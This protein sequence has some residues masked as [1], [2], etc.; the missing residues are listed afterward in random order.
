MRIR[1]AQA[2]L[3]VGIVAFL[4]LSLFWGGAVSA[5]QKR[6]ILVTNDDGIEATA[7]A[8]LVE[9]LSQ[10]AEVVV[11]AP[12]KEHSYGGQ[13]KTTP[14]GMLRLREVKLD[15]AAVAYAVEGTP[16]DAV[17]FGILALGADA[18]FDAVIAGIN[19][20]PALGYEAPSIGIVGAAMEAAALGLPAIAVSQD[21][22]AHRVDVAAEVTVAVLDG[23]LDKGLPAGTVISINVPASATDKPRGLVVARLGEPEL[24]VGGFHKVERDDPRQLWRVQFNKVRRPERETDLD[25][26][27]RGEIIVTPLSLSTPA[28]DLVAEIEGWG[29]QAPERE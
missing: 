15:G 16:V 19:R 23:W 4:V 24:V 1:R 29:L 9:Y 3:T 27:Q 7:L 28:L 18:P 14:S 10:S 12:A 8:G 20:G 2:S 17:Q 5:Q 21:K 22:S 25:W 6:R 26:Y 11:V 13:S